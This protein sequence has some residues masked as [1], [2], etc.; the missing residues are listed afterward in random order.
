M[1]PVLCMLL[2]DGIVLGMYCNQVI[3]L[4]PEESDELKR[5]RLAGII[6]IFI[7]LG[8]MCGGLLSGVICDRIGL[9]NTGRFTLLFY[10]LSAS[11]NFIAIYY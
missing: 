2:L 4:M 10:F 5:N 1:L 11:A 3:R 9:L 6:T 7:G 8:S